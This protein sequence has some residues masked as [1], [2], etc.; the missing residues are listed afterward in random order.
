VQALCRVHLILQQSLPLFAE[1]AAS[2]LSSLVVRWRR[3]GFGHTYCFYVHRLHKPLH[4]L[5]AQDAQKREQRRYKM[6]FRLLAALMPVVGAT[7]VSAVV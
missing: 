5:L 2:V 6:P 7:M 1:C 4:S 3:F